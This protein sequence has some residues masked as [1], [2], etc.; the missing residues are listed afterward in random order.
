MQ[1]AN[2]MLACGETVGQV[3][4]F[5]SATPV[6]DALNLQMY[7]YKT[8]RETVSPS[9]STVTSFPRCM[10]EVF[11][12]DDCCGVKPSNFLSCISSSSQNTSV[13]ATV[14]L[15][16]LNTPHFTLPFHVGKRRTSYPELVF[17]LSVRGRPAAL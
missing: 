3:S 8:E 10:L 4:H 17:G 12:K 14:G 1:L 5:F 15:N 13:C 16:Q 9:T 7:F 6:H 11:Y 2:E